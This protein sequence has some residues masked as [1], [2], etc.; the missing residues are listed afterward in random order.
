MKS[1]GCSRGQCA[2]YITVEPPTPL[3]PDGLL[4]PGSCVDLTADGRAQEVICGGHQFQVRQI[5]EI[6]A[7]CPVDTERHLSFQTGDTV[8]LVRVAE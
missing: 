6:S 8:C 3:K 2:V 4:V 7:T 5:I 1:E